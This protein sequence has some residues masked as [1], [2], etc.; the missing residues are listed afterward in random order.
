[1]ARLVKISHAL[2]DTWTVITGGQATYELALTIRDKHKDEFSKVVMP[3]G[4]FH[5]AHNYVKA[6]CK[7]MRDSGAED[8]LVSAGLCLEATAKKMFEEKA[9]YYQSMHPI[10]MLSEA[11]WRLLWE[12]FET[13]ASEWQWQ[14]PIEAVL[15]TLLD[16][17]NSVT[18]QLQS[19]KTCI[20]FGRSRMRTIFSLLSWKD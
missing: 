18:E 5:Q 20:P 11:L 4:G 13:W 10:G 6:I 7:I 12:T 9:A 1:M 17:T 14:Q 19:I 8:C 16:N 15:R 2:G 3:L